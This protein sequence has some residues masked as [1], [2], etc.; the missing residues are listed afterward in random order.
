M[1]DKINQRKGSKASRTVGGVFRLIGTLLATMLMV[2][3]ITGCIFGSILTVY[4]LNA[5]G[6]EE[7][8]DLDS[9]AIKLGYTSVIYRYDKE[10]G[11]AIPMHY[12]YK[13]DGNRFWV[14]YDQ[15]NDYTK[16]AIVAIEDKRFWEHQGVDWVRT[17]GAFLSQFAPGTVT[18]GGSTVHQQLIKNVTGDN[19][20]RVDRKVR[21]IFRALNLAK[22]YS[23]EQVLETYLNVVPFGAG[24]NGIQ[25]AAKTYFDKDAIDLTLAEAAAIVGITQY[26]GYYNPFLYL[27]NNKER[28]LHVLKEMYDQGLISEKEYENAKTAPL[29]FQERQQRDENKATQSYFV[30]HVIEQVISDLMEKYDYTRSYATQQLYQAGYH[31]FTTVDDDIQKHLEEV[32]ST[33]DNFPTV[34]REEYPQSACVI[35]DL[36]GKIIAMVGGI[37]EKSGDRVFNRATMAK[38]HP[39]SSIKPIG[40]YALALEYNRVRWS[41]VV[42]DWPLNAEDPSKPH[43][44]YPRNYYGTYY[45]NITICYA[46][47]QSVNT[48]AIKLAQELQPRTVFDF[49]HDELEI[50]SLIESRVENGQVLSDVDLSP[51]ALGGLTDGVT[52]LEMVGAYQIFANGGTYTKPYCYT[53]VRSGPDPD[54]LLVLKADTNARPVISEDTSGLLNKLLQRVVSHGT[55]AQ[56]RLSNMPTAGKTGTSN[57]DVDQW[58]IGFTPYYVCQV[59]LG[60]DEQITYDSNGNPIKNSVSYRGV[61]YPPPILFKTIMQPIHDNLEYKPFIESE[62]VVSRTFCTVTG[63]LSGPGCTS[64]DTGWYKLS[65][66]GMPATCNGRHVLEEEE[67]ARQEA[68]AK[69][70]E[71]SG[72]S[73]DDLA[74]ETERRNTRALVITED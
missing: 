68:A 3:I 51:M 41:T 30:D 26:P 14:D 10:T 70:N 44:M 23:R 4:V 8:I 49:L 63:D 74:G 17:F 18:G 6:S 20:L 65:G 7:E 60:Y 47:Q 24:T 31:I 67:K 40:V 11:E 16:K 57:D 61:P 34:S 28:Q 43:Y 58:F 69:E 12:L 36:N 59:W 55:G 54:S 25:S 33:T 62:G 42:D 39:G 15:I 48:I 71:S 9:D 21:E 56:A 50:D 32:Y 52:P 45:R 19:D 72:E 29:N 27:E 13:S 66:N 53:E 5:I 1:S 38:R 22:R 37:G 46:I 2:G 64:V 35:T 73:G